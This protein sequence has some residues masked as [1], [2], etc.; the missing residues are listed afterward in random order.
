[1]LAGEVP[2]QGRH[3]SAV[4]ASVIADPPRDLRQLRPEVPR[5]LAAVVAKALE[6]D[7]GDR[8]QRVEDLAAAIAPFGPPELAGEVV[9]TSARFGGMSGTWARVEPPPRP[10]HRGRAVWIAAAVGALVVAVSA[11]RYGLR[12]E[13]SA[14][15]APPSPASTEATAASPVAPAAAAA[16]PARS[17]SA[18]VASAPA[19]LGAPTAAAEPR[20]AAT[21]PPRA[22]AEATPPPRSTRP[23]T[24][25]N[26][27][28]L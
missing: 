26:P 17:A 19:A 13:P 12:E 2:F 9:P 8:F 3:A 24:R 16:P 28:H 18:A 7:P 10:E 23:S 25:S 6:K 5:K 1:M 4:V 15:A 22:G 14:V 11:L 20:A 27:L 21:A